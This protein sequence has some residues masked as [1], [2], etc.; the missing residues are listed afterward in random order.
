MSSVA[1]DITGFLF[2][3]MVIVFSGIRLTKYGDSIAELTGLGRAWVGLILMASV[4]SLPELMT[5]IS[6]VA[7]IH[8]PNLAAGD[9]F[10]SC[11]FNLLILSFIDTRI[12]RPLTSQ[13][14]SSH[15]LAGLLGIILIGISGIAVLTRD[16]MPSIF[17]ISPFSVVLIV[18]Y[19][20]SMWGIYKIEHS[21]DIEPA[22]VEEDSPSRKDELKSVLFKYSVNAVL[23]IAA[24][25]FLPFFGENIAHASGLGNTFFGTVFLAASTSLPELVVSFSAI[26][27]KAFDMLVGNLLGSNIFNMLILAIDDI[28][29]FK[30]SLFVKI[31]PEHME[32]IIT[33]IIM[34]AIVGLG[35]L[36]RP[37]KKFWRLSF[38][39]FLIVMLYIGLMIILYLKK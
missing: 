21:N 28:L 39:T 38:D 30:E 34:T 37:T 20:F 8:A 36:I 31:E 15:L 13:V 24:A 29:Y 25:V 4:T 26:K 32:T 6:S 33:I 2:C 11:V 18:V 27:M 35:L 7:I 12:S 9:V 17:W 5:G 10:G 22:R 3:T 16:I 14:K 1:I 23:V 19:L